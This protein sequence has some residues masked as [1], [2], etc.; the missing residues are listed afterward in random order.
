MPALL[1][2]RPAGFITS[3]QIHALTWASGVCVC[4]RVCAVSDLKPALWPSCYLGVSI[5]SHSLPLE[6]S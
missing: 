5:Q 3:I 4:E 1:V 6:E 2:Y